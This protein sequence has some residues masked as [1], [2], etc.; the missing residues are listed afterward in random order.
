M[1]AWLWLQGEREPVAAAFLRQTAL[2]GEKACR[3][4]SAGGWCCLAGSSAWE[5]VFREAVS[6]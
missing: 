4:L 5:E 3:A 2:E 1:T 6:P